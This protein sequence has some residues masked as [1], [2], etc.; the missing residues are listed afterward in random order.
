MATKIEAFGSLSSIIEAIALL[1]DE[2]KIISAGAS[3]SNIVGL[4]SLENTIHI[5]A[6]GA[7]PQGGT[8]SG[9][10]GGNVEMSVMINGVKVLWLVPDPID[11]GENSGGDPP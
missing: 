3:I 7:V 4:F 6:N 10:Y 9:R 8:E 2:A 5:N 1:P 11:D